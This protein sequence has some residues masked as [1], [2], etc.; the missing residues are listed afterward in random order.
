ML[1]LTRTITQA[2]ATAGGASAS[3]EAAII[4]FGQALGAGVLR[5]EEL[6]SVLEQAPALAEAIAKGMGRTTG[7]LKAMGEQGLITVEIIAALEKMRRDR[8]AVLSHAADRGA[9]IRPAAQ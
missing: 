1:G 2:M 6:N 3:A 7:E 8:G 4:Q 9:G 5:G